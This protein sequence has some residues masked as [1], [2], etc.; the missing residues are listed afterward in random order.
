MA[1]R[2]VLR[3]GLGAAAVAACVSTAGCGDQTAAPQYVG[4]VT[5]PGADAVVA[6]LSDG[7]R[8][9]FYLCGGPSTYAT[10]THWFQ[11]PVGPGGALQIESGGFV[12]TG[13]IESGAGKV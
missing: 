12:L 10:L 1:S 7:E 8:V 9:Q 2:S 5:D 13:D 11:G 6:A 4:R 3:M